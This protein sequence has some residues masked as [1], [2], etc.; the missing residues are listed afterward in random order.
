M[1][2][3]RIEWFILKALAFLFKVTYNN[4]MNRQEMQLELLNHFDYTDF[5]L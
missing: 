4:S 1:K 2:N 5:L 3:F